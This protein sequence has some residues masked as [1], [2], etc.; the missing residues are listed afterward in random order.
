MGSAR[1]QSALRPQ[2]GIDGLGL[3]RGFRDRVARGVQGLSQ[4]DKG[5]KIPKGHQNPRY[6]G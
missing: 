5:N 3:G 1:T 4:N 2:H 6:L